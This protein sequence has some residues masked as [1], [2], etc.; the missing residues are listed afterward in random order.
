[1]LNKWMHLGGS[2][3]RLHTRG[4]SDLF[5]HAAMSDDYDHL[6]RTVMGWVVVR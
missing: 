2:A 1:M 5:M 6:L 3:A 4:A